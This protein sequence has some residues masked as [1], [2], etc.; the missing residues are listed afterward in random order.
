MADSNGGNEVQMWK[1]LLLSRLKSWARL[2]RTEMLVRKTGRKVKDQN[3][4]PSMPCDA[5]G[6]VSHRVQYQR[7]SLKSAILVYCRFCLEN[8]RG[9]SSRGKTQRGKD[10]KSIFIPIHVLDN[11]FF[12]FLFYTLAHWRGE[13]CSQI[14]REQETSGHWYSE[15]ENAERG[16]LKRIS[17]TSKAAILLKC[18]CYVFARSS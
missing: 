8:E 12:S 18:M 13:V 10:F 6:D 16:T 2:A 7:R 1:Q 5:F 4:S 3:L 11:F 15:K 9:S 14:S 17:T